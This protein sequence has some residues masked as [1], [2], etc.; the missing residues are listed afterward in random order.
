MNNAERK[1]IHR[2][3]APLLRFRISS[4]VW[5][6]T[7]GRHALNSLTET[8]MERP[9]KVIQ[10]TENLP[11]STDGAHNLMLAL[12]NL[13]SNIMCLLCQNNE[14]TDTQT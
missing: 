13:K 8:A 11:L 2:L 5:Q 1:D 14:L 4:S 12:E 6:T 7:P 9:R 3:L 10:Q